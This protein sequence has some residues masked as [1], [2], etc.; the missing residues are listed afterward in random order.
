VKRV[1]VFGA[2]GSLGQGVVEEIKDQ[3]K[4]TG[5]YRSRTLE[6][7]GIDIRRVDICDT[8][9]FQNLDA[10]YDAVFMVAGAMP[11]MMSGYSPQDY[12]DVNMTGTLNV[13]EFCRRNSVK[14]IYLR[15]D[16]F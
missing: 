15:D 3:F 14:K 7:E 6:T 13:L 4:L 9:S 16:F 11:A 8:D 12:I 2:S 1:V 5:T 10:N